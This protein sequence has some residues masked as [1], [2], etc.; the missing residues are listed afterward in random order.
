MRAAVTEASAKQARGNRKPQRALGILD[1]KR[2]ATELLAE[3]PLTAALSEDAR[4][5]LL[6]AGCEMASFAPGALVLAEGAPSCGTAF[7]VA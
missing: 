5:R 6:Q 2:V 7:L 1:Q 4:L 3:A